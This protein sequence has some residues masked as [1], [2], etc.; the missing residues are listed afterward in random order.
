[1]AAGIGG[2]LL[3]FTGLWHIFEWM[4]AG[5]NRDTVRLVPVGILY[6]ALGCL[7]VLGIGGWITLAAAT[8]ITAAGMAAAFTLRSR[9]LVRGW[10]TW[11]FILIDATIVA[12]L[13]T[14]LLG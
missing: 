1:M 2:A 7:I 14:A 8:A 13:L 4:M 3:V 6:A 11:A 5:H 9:S 10:V 12:A